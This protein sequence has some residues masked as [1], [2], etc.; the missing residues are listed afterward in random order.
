MVS[1]PKISHARRANPNAN[2]TVAMDMQVSRTGNLL[3]SSL[4]D[5]I[6]NP[7]HH[8]M[9]F[10][11]RLHTS[12]H[13]S[14]LWKFSSGNIGCWTGII[15]SCLY[16]H[17]QVQNAQQSVIDIGS[18]FFVGY[19]RNALWH[20]PCRKTKMYKNEL[21]QS[22]KPCNWECKQ[23]SCSKGIGQLCLN[24]RWFRS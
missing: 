9:W 18:I 24:S 6:F 16:S 10:P 22:S 17:A 8:H 7:V 5:C 2:W 1:W 3:H 21:P 15:G 20:G 23:P 11:R 14:F 13:A 12:E 4:M 19:G